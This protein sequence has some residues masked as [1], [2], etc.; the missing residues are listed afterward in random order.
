MKSLS[1]LVSIEK[2][3]NRIIGNTSSDWSLVKMGDFL[4][5]S[6]E[7]LL[8]QL[9]ESNKFSVIKKFETDPNN[10][11]KIKIKDNMGLDLCRGDEL[12]LSY[13]EYELM[14][15][16]EIL[17]PGENYKKGD[18][19]YVSGGEACMNVING[20]V[21]KTEFIVEKVGEKGEILKISTKTDGKYTIPPP[22]ENELISN[23]GQNAKFSLQYR[24]NNHR[25]TLE[26]RISIIG[27]EAPYTVINLDYP[28]VDKFNEGQLF[29]QKWEMFLDKNYLLDTKIN[30]EC[31][32]LRDY[33]VHLKIPFML[34]G[35]TSQHLLYNYFVNRMDQKVL[36]IENRLAKLEN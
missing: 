8:Y 19:L 13:K 11:K 15:V 16:F 35:S 1:N 30:I 9:L 20:L 36:E 23:N 25:K 22:L 26:R 32:I 34:P 6:G 21:E 12:I 5:F 2:N 18:I 28:L 27:F 31:Q 17:N 14:A 24:E 7:D 4:R 3:T 10:P 33:S 29:C